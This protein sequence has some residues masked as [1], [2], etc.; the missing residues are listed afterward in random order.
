[1]MNQG[2]N[3]DVR[4]FKRQFLDGV[5]RGNGYLATLPVGVV[6]RH[7]AP[8]VPIVYGTAMTAYLLDADGDIIYFMLELP[9]DYDNTSTY[10]AN[11]TGIQ[12]D[13]L[14]LRLL[15][16]GY[17]VN[18]NTMSIESLNLCR[19]GTAS[20][21]TDTGGFSALTLAST[22]TA[23]RTVPSTAVAEYLF[24]FSGL[25]L[26]PGDVVCAKLV[27]NVAT[28]GGTDGIQVFGVQGMYRTNV[29]PTNALTDS[30]RY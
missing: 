2:G 28:G 26:R 24:D 19:A 22:V 8:G 12:S 30:T 1:M 15:A 4:D 9:Q 10:D 14:F 21:G 17:G 13:Q 6:S 20:N 5:N 11:K 23:A 3:V 7:V 16:V 18:T 27:C 25:N 29:V